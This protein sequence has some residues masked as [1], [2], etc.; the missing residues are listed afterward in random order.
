[1]SHTVIRHPNYNV[2]DVIWAHE[3]AQQLLQGL[4]EVVV[5]APFVVCRLQI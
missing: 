4:A 5:S 2:G 1:M 3:E